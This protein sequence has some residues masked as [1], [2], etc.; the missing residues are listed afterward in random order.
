MTV[1]SVNATDLPRFMACNGSRLLDKIEQPNELHQFPTPRDEGNAAHYVA[2]MIMSG[3]AK[4][5]DLLDTKAPNGVFISADMLSHV[6]EYVTLLH[7]IPNLQMEYNVSFSVFDWQISARTDAIGHDETTVHVVDFKYGWRTVEPHD[8]WTL[9]AYVMGYAGIHVGETS[10][11]MNFKLTIVQP[12]PY[13]PEGTV[14]TWSIDGELLRKRFELLRSVMA[15]PSDA[16]ITT[17]HCHNCPSIAVCPAVRAASMNAIDHCEMAYSDDLDNDELSYELD[18]LNR[19]QSM[20]KDRQSALQELAKHRIKKGEVI[21]NYSIETSYGN[22]IWKENV[23][24]SVLKMLTGKDLTEAK[25]C[26]P[27]QAEKKYGISETVVNSLTTK[28]ISGINLTRVSADQKAKRLLGV[29]K[30][31]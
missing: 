21:N 26:T 9:L 24:A 13:H 3:K 16:L 20:V 19:A 6:E 12:R 22:R 8:N 27:A 10:N 29:K 18:V 23:N 31:G 30:D 14:R 25:I 5:F 7:N 2:M 11:P 28:K 4:A 1:R 17:A 15:S